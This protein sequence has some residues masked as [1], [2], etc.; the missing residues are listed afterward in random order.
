MRVCDEMQ[1]SV[2]KF[3]AEYVILHKNKVSFF[4]RERVFFS[5]IIGDFMI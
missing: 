4:T 1:L 3:K 2:D 5:C